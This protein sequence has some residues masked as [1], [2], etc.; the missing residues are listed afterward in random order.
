MGKS[1][2]SLGGMVGFA[3]IF[4]LILCSVTAHSSHRNDEKAKDA[5]CSIKPLLIKFTTNFEPIWDDE[6]SDAGGDLSI[7]RPTS[8][9]ADFFPVGDTAVT[10][11]ESPDHAAV[12]VEDDGTGLVKPPR[13][14]K[15]I[16]SDKGSS[17]R[18]PV[19]IYEM[20]PP[21]NYTCLGDVAMKSYKRS[22]DRKMYRC[23][24]MDLMEKG[25]MFN[26]WKSK[27][28]GAKK[29]V[30]FWI[31]KERNSTMSKGI[32]TGA[33]L[34]VK[35]FDQLVSNLYL[36]SACKINLTDTETKNGDDQDQHNGHHHR[37]TDS[38]NCVFSAGGC[39]IAA[40]P[41]P[42]MAC[43]CTLNT[44]NCVGQVQQ[45]AQSNAYYCINP[46][47]SLGT[48]LQG[49]GNCNAYSDSCDCTYYPGGCRISSPSIAHTACKCLYTSAW[50]C[51]GI[52]VKCKEATSAKCIT[53]DTSKESCLQ[54][55]GACSYK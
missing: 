20:I 43:Y 29:D 38:C 35:G 36:L 11:H 8:R 23:V 49:E 15:K 27:H 48:C 13:K 26:L 25:D 19:T 10:S 9:N 2:L 33:F 55:D 46:D 28:F 37:T 1:M 21:P 32:S 47:T 42:N 51:G 16:W 22:P 53:P 41:P 14:F 24:R 3:T 5:D 34:A 40:T 31:L 50:S 44:V 18:K 17:A 7:W 4:V 54:G 45:C 12:L 52:I 30:S 6:G 39:M